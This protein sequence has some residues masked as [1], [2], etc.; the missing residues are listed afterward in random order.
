MPC[1]GHFAESQLTGYGHGCLI[2]CVPGYENHS[3]TDCAPNFLCL[4][5][6]SLTDFL[7]DSQIR[8]EH[9]YQNDSGPDFRIDF[10]PD[11][12]IDFWPA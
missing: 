11:F 2:Y 8:S 1:C 4:A 9:N 10:G 7:Q 6:D 5:I 12:P 3:L